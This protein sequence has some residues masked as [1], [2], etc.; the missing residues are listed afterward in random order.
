[1]NSSP[2]RQWSQFLARFRPEI[3]RVAKEARTRLRKML[4]R[5]VELIYDNYNALVIGFGPS[6]RA[7][8]A[9]VSLAVYPRWVNL[10]FLQGARLP[11]PHRVLKG[12]GKQVRR[13]LLESAGTLDQPAVREL[14]AAAVAAQP[15]WRQPQR[16]PRTV[17]KA[18]SPKHRPRRP[19]EGST[20]VAEVKKR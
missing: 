4:P 16:Q 15:G 2:E 20:G 18:V 10:F 12:S 3:A 9:V 11:D 5:P 6:E 13:I 8:E 19:R 14:I 7:S 1:V 17:V